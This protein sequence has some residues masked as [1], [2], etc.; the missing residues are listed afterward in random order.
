MQGCRFPVAN[1]CVKLKVLVLSSSLCVAKDSALGQAA[2]LVGG[3]RRGILLK[4]NFGEIFSSF[5]F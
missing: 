3:L 2:I 1:K 5:L 4:G